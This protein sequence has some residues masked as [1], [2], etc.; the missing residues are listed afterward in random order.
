MQYLI[1]TAEAFN[2]EIDASLKWY[3]WLAHVS[4]KGLQVI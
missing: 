2:T 1:K 4:E 3:N